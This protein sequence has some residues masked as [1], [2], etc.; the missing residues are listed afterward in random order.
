MKQILITNDD[1][2][3]S[4]GLLALKN[5][6]NDLAKI[7][8][9]APSSQ[10]SACSHSITLSRPLR[11]IEVEKNY[12]KLDDATPSDC[13]YFALE[14][15]YK[16]KKPDLIISGIN[17]GANLGEDISYS[18]TCGGA[19]EGVLQGIASIAVSLY[20]QNDSLNKYGFDL[21]CEVVRDLVIKIFKQGFPLPNREFLNLNIPAVPKNKYKGL[22]IVPI[23]NRFYDTKIK[24]GLDPRGGKYYWLGEPSVKSLSDKNYECDLNAIFDGFASLT[25]IKLDF[26]AYESIEKLKNWNK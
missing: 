13:V 19:M 15:F 5:A 16:N 9:V 1:G 25:P 11:L 4:K 7:I 6:L 26:S 2:F 17:H 21:A 14:E 23:G 10:K 24:T 12:F 3:D 20:Y 22:K 8:I 18:G